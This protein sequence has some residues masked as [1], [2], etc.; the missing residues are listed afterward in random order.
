MA[1]SNWFYGVGCFS[2]DVTIHAVRKSGIIWGAIVNDNLLRLD[3][4][5]RRARAQIPDDEHSV[6]SNQYSRFPYSNI[7]TKTAYT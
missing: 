6:R 2:L 3:L 4:R 7:Q 1:I 5:T